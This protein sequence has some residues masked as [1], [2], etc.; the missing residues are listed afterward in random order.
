[1][2]ALKRKTFRIQQRNQHLKN[3]LEE[4]Y[5]I[6]L[7]TIDIS[8][9]ERILSGNIVKIN[10][11]IYPEIAKEGVGHIAASDDTELQYQFNFLN[12]LRK[13][14]SSNK[15][16][17]TCGVLRYSSY[18][19]NSY[20]PIIL[21]PVEVDFVE[22][23]IVLSSE[24]MVN[25]IL[26]DDLQS[27][28]GFDIAQLE[29]NA[30]LYQIDEYCVNL[31]EAT[32]SEY[33]I[34]NFLTIATVEYFENS[35]SFDYFT[36][37][38]SIFERN[39]LEVYTDYFN[40]INAISP[41]NIYQKWV[42]LK[43]DEGQSFVVDGKLGTGKTYTIINAIADSISKKKHVLYVS[44]DIDSIYKLEQDL[45]N[46]QMG[47]Y[48]YN[49]CK[50]STPIEIVERPLEQIREE[51]V[52][53]ETLQPISDYER[54]LNE[55]IH[56]CKYSK[57]ISKLA[58]IKNQQPD[59]TRIPID[60]ILEANEIK[61]VYLRL[62]EI[63]EILN[64]IE[65]LDINVWSKI[66]QYYDKRHIK[67][68]V[69]NTKAYFNA[70]KSFNTA[71]KDFCRK[72]DINLPENFVNAQ[73]LL[74]YI[75]E[76]NKIMP[77][78]VWVKNFNEE[79]IK[80][81]L[82]S[83]SLYQASNEDVK[84]AL[85]EEVIKSYETGTAELLLSVITY[86]HLTLDDSEYITNVLQ[87]S[88]ELTTLKKT[89]EQNINIINRDIDIFCNSLEQSVFTPTHLSYVTKL[90]NLL[91]NVDIPFTW[92]DFFQRNKNIARTYFQTY[93]AKLD[94]FV[95]LKN[96]IIPFLAK[97]TSFTYDQTK[98]LSTSGDFSKV[99]STMFDRKVLKK[100][101]M[102]ND[103][104]NHIVLD[105]I[106][107]GDAIYNDATN[108]NLL[109]KL[110]IDEFTYNFGK[111]IDLYL[112][113]TD[114]EELIFKHQLAIRPN[115]IVKKDAFVVTYEEFIEKEEELRLHYERLK[116]FG[117]NLHSETIMDLNIEVK[118]WLTYLINSVKATL[119]L[120]RLFKDKVPSLSSIIRIINADRD[121]INLT[122]QLDVRSSEMI[123][124]L[125]T[126]YDGLNTNCE[127]ITNLITCYSEFLKQL[128][129]KEVINILFDTGKI[130][131]MME[132]FPTVNNL[133]EVK[134]AK[135]NLFSKY[136]MGGQTKLLECS[137]DNSLRQL[138]KFDE[139]VQEIPPLFTLFEHV[140]F[141]EKLGLRGLCEGILKSKY[142]KGIAD[143]YIYST[144]LDYQNELVQKF[145]VLQ[146]NGS[147]MLWL[148]NF[149]YYEHNY[150]ESNIR[151]LARGHNKGDKRALNHLQSIAFN[152]YNKI[153]E[154]L[155]WSKKVFLAD[156]DIFNSNID[157]SKF[158][159]ILCDDIH[160]STSFKYNKVT[161]A[162]QCV[163]F[164]DSSRLEISANNAFKKIPKRVIFRLVESYTKDNLDYGNIPN[165]GNQ[166]IYD[167]HR[168]TE[169]IDA[170]SIQ[171]IASII[172]D[173][174]YQ[175]RSKLVDI[176]YASSNYKLEVYRA[177]IKKL[178]EIF[179]S[180][181]ILNIL[182]TNIRLVRAPIEAARI[183]NESY[184]M[185]DD[186]K[187]LSETQLRPIVKAYATGSDKV[188]IIGSE[189][190]TK[191]Y[192]IINEAKPLIEVETSKD[193]YMDELVKLISSEL[194]ERGFTVEQGIGRID[195][196]IKGK[197]SK[198]KQVIPNVGIIV[199]GVYNNGSYSLVED[200]QYYNKEYAKNGWQIY[201]FFV[202]DIIENLQP[203]LDTISQFLANK[204]T[205]SMHQ[206]KIDDFIK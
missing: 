83:I 140:R 162:K 9:L 122:E 133:A 132:D 111:F 184:F 127:E 59:I 196:M 166:Y 6:E 23:T 123:H 144:Y 60:A 183:N 58:L 101:H 24:A 189:K 173:N 187:N 204:D 177:L 158:D 5:Y 153:V 25:P 32:K 100:E 22:N 145:P 124:Y 205:K 99:L 66:E 41:T 79:K 137:L 199:E 164:G 117:I 178:S 168:V 2:K 160:L 120:T 188:I 71:I 89:I 37:Q 175:D 114:D 163:L 3:I 19:N 131:Q 27:M 170:S 62:Q 54:A 97:D 106:D 21:I 50:G 55:S 7:G 10:D 61:D 109:G 181:E 128:K 72:Y 103:K 150:N 105:F 38:R 20:A 81:L 159:I 4:N 151:D 179:E 203:K 1:M 68:I 90:Y 47:P 146:E 143:M 139:R 14:S 70:T 36:T 93:K 182:K 119:E 116:F 63:E 141:F 192:S 138:N 200:Y 80:E 98:K 95:E 31:A 8:V 15:I 87:N 45:H 136:F 69:D 75:D 174:Y 76:F 78:V 126:T 35:S 107:A 157:L 91:K 74:S 142:S 40:K 118:E 30:N 12:S 185:Y 33:S 155:Y 64:N 44:Q 130:N 195:L 18:G 16:F 65:P 198:G 88:V 115:S 28:I 202:D 17:L 11:I 49:L 165:Q 172:V 112:S 39:A 176:I 186:L 73:K 29:H 82:H 42:L 84:K 108:Y 96:I 134:L 161:E 121:Y 194:Q 86:R 180:N 51:R 57:I 190:P 26:Y 104:I 125:G 167:F 52:G 34:G 193:I 129:T 201:I 154:E 156:I 113:L 147:I 67:E 46:L 191:D 48:T 56:G 169:Y 102:T 135:H 77:P 206:F 148:D 92:I 85:T 197:I 149:N 94:N 171:E 110:T 43:I 152:D 53:L 13:N